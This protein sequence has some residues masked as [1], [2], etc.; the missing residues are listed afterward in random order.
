MLVLKNAGKVMAEGGEPL[1]NAEVNALRVENTNAFAFGVVTTGPI[2]IYWGDGSY[3]DVGVKTTNYLVVKNYASVGNWNITISGASNIM[4]LYFNNYVSNNKIN[5]N[6]TWLRQFNNLKSLFL[7]C[8]TFSGELGSVIDSM[9]VEWLY[10][11][12]PTAVPYTFNVSNCKSFWQRCKYI[13][14]SSSYNIGAGSLSDIDMN[15]ECAY[16]RL[17]Y[18]RLTGS[19]AGIIK[20]GYTKLTDISIQT[21]VTQTFP[22]ANISDWV[23]PDT[24][25]TIVHLGDCGTYGSLNGFNFKNL[26][27]FYLPGAFSSPLDLRTN[28]TFINAIQQRM[29]YFILNGL[30]NTETVFDL[31]TFT[32]ANYSHVII[33]T[34]EGYNKS[35][36]DLTAL[37]KKVTNS[38]YVYGGLNNGAITGVVDSSCIALYISFGNIDIN[39][40]A[41][42][43][44][45]IAVRSAVSM[46][47]LP[48]FIGD[49]SG[50]EFTSTNNA[51]FGVTIIRCP[52]IH[53][54]VTT[55][56]Y[57][58]TWYESNYDSIMLSS[59]QNL[60]G[61]LSKF[62]LWCNKYK[63]SLNNC[64]YTNIPGFIRKV[65]VN[66]NTCLKA[67]GGMTAIYV[68]GN[69]DNNQ[70]TGI[71]QQPPLGTFAG[72]INDLT[73]VQ[74]DNLE[75]GKDYT[76]IGTS[77]PWTDKEC[78]WILTKLKNSATD[79]SLRYR[80][81]WSY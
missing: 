73:E 26:I 2:R 17:Y 36:G 62:P 23:I 30:M 5:T 69:V 11:E 4:I 28:T 10:V 37:S 65:F 33:N 22:F 39:V 60:N 51:G 8:A 68:Q 67:A 15:L 1:V 43:F 53:G 44:K 31:S 38:F 45:L 27:S 14:F 19:M 21:W 16:I 64:A 76:G 49:L 9:K 50:C 71:E 47:G 78:I 54:D 35:F 61:D 46:V 32:L 29:A 18:L 24:L 57:N 6:L 80:S 59:C 72:N 70:L 81:T 75:A 55:F 34:N 3:T 74:I 40:S 52:N 77:I 7:Y 20:N 42:E 41:T 13:Y 63:I 12:V 66:R 48:N 25:K 79:S 58:T 56:T